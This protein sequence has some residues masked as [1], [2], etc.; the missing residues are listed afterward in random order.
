[1]S[2]PADL[3]SA[4]VLLRD[5][6]L[7]RLQVLSPSTL[8]LIDESHLH[9]GHAGA[10]GG[11]RHF[12]LQIVSNQFHGHSTLARHRLVYDCVR[13]LMP[14]PVHALAIEAST[15]PSEGLS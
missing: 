7:Q 4:A 2:T 1:M 3:P 13:D 8:N 15:P 5:Q 9:I 10:E 11:A 14:Y 6:L 12:R